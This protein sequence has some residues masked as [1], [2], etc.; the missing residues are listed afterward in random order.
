MPPEWPRSRILPPH[1]ASA[2]DCDD[3]E[4]STN[5]TFTPRCA[6]AHSSLPTA[7]L[8][9]DRYARKI[10]SPAASGL[11]HST[12]RCCGLVDRAAEAALSVCEQY[13]FLGLAVS[14]VE[15]SAVGIG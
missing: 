7:A 15:P 14:I 5:V 6:A 8:E 13:T 10:S 4:S 9:N 3:S 2:C 11:I 1:W 12:S